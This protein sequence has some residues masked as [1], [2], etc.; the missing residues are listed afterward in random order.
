MQYDEDGAL[1]TAWVPELRA[2]PTAALRHQPFAASEEAAAACGFRPGVDYPLPL[3]DPAT[4]IAVGPRKQKQQKTT[5]GAGDDERTAAVALVERR[6]GRRG[7]SPP[8]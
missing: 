3:V 7:S 8:P 1:I 6:R 5:A 2:L 4:Q